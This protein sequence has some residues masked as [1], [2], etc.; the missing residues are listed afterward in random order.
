MLR[1][2]GTQAAKESTLQ[3]DGISIVIPKGT[4]ENSITTV[5]RAVKSAWPEFGQRPLIRM[6]K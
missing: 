4:D 1:I 2:G 3:L 5:L 6:I